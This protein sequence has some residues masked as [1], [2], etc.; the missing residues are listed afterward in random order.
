MSRIILA[1]VLVITGSRLLAGEPNELTTEQ[2]AERGRKSLAVITTPGRDGKG[3]GLGTGF[4][5]SADGLIATN[6]HVIGEG[7]PITVELPDG[8][9]H[10]VIT[11]QASDRAADLA[12]IKIDAKGLKPLDLGDSDKLRDGQS[13][14]ALGN[15]QG[16]KHSVVDGVVSA[17]RVLDGRK[18]IQLAIPLEPG[19]SG[20]PLLDRLGRVQG[21][22]TLRSAVTENLGF[23]MPI[24]ALKPL[25]NKPNPVPMATWMTLGALDPDEWKPLFGARWRQRAGR[26]LVEGLGTG[27]GGRSICL[28]KK[29]SPELPFELA[30]TLK[31]GDEAGA[32]GLVFCS[33]GDECHYGFYPTNGEFRFTRF[34]G[35]DVYSWKVLA[36]KRSD[37]YRPGDWNTIKVRLE[38]G[39][40]RCFVNGEMLMEIAD[41]TYASGMVGLAKFRDTAAEFKN[42]GVARSIAG[43]SPE[44]RA[45]I[46]KTIDGLAPGKP[47]PAN[48]V[49]SLSG[50]SASGAIILERAAA[51]ERQAEQLRLLAQSV[52]QKRVRDELVKVFAHPEEEID[53]AHAA[54]LV[55][56]LDNDELSVPAYL[57]EIDRFAKKVASSLSNKADE[58]AKLAALNKFFF[59]QRGFHGSRSD[60]YN[61]SN[62]YL[63][64]VIDDREGLPIT[65]S[66][67]YI[68][69]ARRIG[70]KVEGVAL[71]GHFVVR[72]VRTKGESQMIDVFEGG[73]VLTREQA[74]EKVMGTAGIK[75]QEEHLRAVNK[76][77]II[78][79]MLQNLLNLTREDRDLE[80]ARRYLD[81]MLDVD[82]SLGRE[83]WMRAVLNYQ[84]G[85][86]DAAR[87][88]ADWLLEHAPEGIDLDDVR[89]M[90]RSLDQSDK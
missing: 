49:D 7:R 38:K 76:R 1:T 80:R 52:Q 43:P 40:F 54:L 47:L 12:V 72:L 86:K 5:I 36:Q 67:L 58:N 26:L 29:S 74:A 32:A 89:E 8:S 81:A 83:H 71:P 84:T 60:Y 15:P 73:K 85:H 3:R 57:A 44:A 51:L 13:V 39:K 53:L 22:L 28:L 64:E 21:I 18:M 4:V 14:V 82:S 75:L 46:S 6:L 77:S 68:E 25:L 50:E 42:F 59:E 66:V 17:Q 31:M 87:R 34:D 48:V 10:E 33:D 70:L 63:N 2:I 78:V 16:L 62:S 30:V 41:D 11:V 9:K 65:L 88:D 45:R 61:R 37:K 56:Q 55:A 27:F 79:R 24:N 23:A 69:L 35:P 20:G 19:N 90:R